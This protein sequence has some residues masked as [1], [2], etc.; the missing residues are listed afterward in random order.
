MLGLL[1]AR[2][3]EDAVAAVQEYGQLLPVE[4]EGRRNFAPGVPF[5]KI[6][7][8][9]IDRAR[10]PGGRAMLRREIE[11][12]CCLRGAQAARMLMHCGAG[13][14]Q[15]VQ[16][17]E[18]AGCGGE[19]VHRY[20]SMVSM[21]AISTVELLIGLADLLEEHRAGKQRHEKKGPQKQP[22]HIV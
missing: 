3:P 15:S 14:V 16:C 19:T 1:A 13:H 11:A 12:L 17:Y 21:E 6:G 10:E 9:L 5:G 18:P 2:R 22:I 7:A 20:P 4:V 8:I